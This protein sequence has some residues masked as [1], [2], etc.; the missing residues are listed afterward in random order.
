MNYL[1]IRNKI[2]MFFFLWK[3]SAAQRTELNFLENIKRND[4][5]ISVSNRLIGS[6]GSFD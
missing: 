4:L 3:L 1:L 5:Y 2:E 6:D